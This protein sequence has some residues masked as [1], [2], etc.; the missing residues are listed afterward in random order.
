VQ[1]VCRAILLEGF[2]LA[3]VEVQQLCLVGAAGAS[4]PLEH[5]QLVKILCL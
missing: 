5:M 1:P 2:P 4:S 3:F